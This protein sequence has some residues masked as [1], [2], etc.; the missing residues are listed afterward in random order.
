MCVRARASVVLTKSTFTLTLEWYNESVLNEFRMHT[1]A[2]IAWTENAKL[3]ACMGGV[4]ACWVMENEQERQR[5]NDWWAQQQQQQQQLSVAHFDM[6]S[7]HMDSSVR[8][9][10]STIIL[11]TA[12]SHYTA[13][14]TVVHT[15]L[16]HIY[17][18]H[19]TA[20]DVI[21]TRLNLV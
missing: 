6:A 9:S 16:I 12:L 2:S 7:N 5:V 14:N 15:L 10:Q 18:A 17:K 19:T 21:G 11:H 3:N 4:R 8:L 1:Q 13:H 20:M